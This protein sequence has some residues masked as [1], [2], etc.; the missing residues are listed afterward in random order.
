MYSQAQ[1]SHQL[2]I[3]NSMPTNVQPTYQPT[4]VYSHP[5]PHVVYSSAGAPNV[6]QNRRMRRGPNQNKQMME[7]CK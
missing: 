7:T 2:P 1:S 6:N 5:A 3:Y 4:M